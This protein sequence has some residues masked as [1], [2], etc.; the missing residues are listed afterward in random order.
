MMFKWIS[1]ALRICATVLLVSFLSI[2]TTGYIVNSYVES[3][4]KQLELPIEVQPFA[5]SGVWGKLW[6]ASQPEPE[7]LAQD[8][9][10]PPS[11]AAPPQPSQEAGALTEPERG[12]GKYGELDKMNGGKDGDSSTIDT[13]TDVEVMAQPDSEEIGELADPGQLTEA[14]RT[15]LYGSVVAKLGAEQ[16]Q[17]L[18]NLLNGGLTREEFTRLETSLRE[19]LDPQEYAQMMKELEPW[20]DTSTIVPGV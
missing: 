2:W 12:V 17:L 4:L 16:L 13:M 3:M 20:I 14:Q 8:S 18:S 11:P 19:L 15:E 6:G 5:V 10:A 7:Q 1:W 9:T